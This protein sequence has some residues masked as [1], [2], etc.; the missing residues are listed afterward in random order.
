MSQSLSSQR[1]R[2]RAV[3]RRRRRE[4]GEQWRL[5]L[6]FIGQGD[7]YAEVADRAK[8]SVATVRRAVKRALDERGPESVETFVALQRARLDKAMRHTDSMIEEGDPRA[9]AAMLALL[10]QIER[11]WGLQRALEASRES[12]PEALI[13]A[14]TPLKSLESQVQFPPPNT[15]PAAQDAGSV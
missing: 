13:L 4:K 12:A 6:D 14:P 3:A 11:Y 2:A 5:W 9:V 8:V 1:A 15:V 10:P 7:I